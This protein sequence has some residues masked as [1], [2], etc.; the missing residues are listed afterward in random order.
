MQKIETTLFRVLVFTNCCCIL[1]AYYKKI[2]L[3]NK[4]QNYFS[5][6]PLKHFPSNR[7]FLCISKKSDF[8]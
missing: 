4:I 1:N 2:R 7:T 8:G 5:F 6:L 3:Y